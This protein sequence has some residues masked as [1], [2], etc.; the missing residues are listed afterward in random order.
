MLNRFNNIQYISDYIERT[1]K[2]TQS[3]NQEFN[4]NESNK[5]NGKRMTN[6]GTFRAYVEAYLRNQPLINQKMTFLVRQLAPTQHGLPIEIYVFSKE[7][8]WAAYESIQANIF[9]H[10]LASVPEFDLRVFQ[11]PSGA[12]FNKLVR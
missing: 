2:E 7:K 3:Y 6:V 11:E 1:K 8:E 10:I 5:V 9:N 12:D 4:I